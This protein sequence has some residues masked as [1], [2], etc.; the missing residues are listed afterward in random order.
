VGKL[1]PKAVIEE[2]KSAYKHAHVFDVVEV[3]KL[4]NYEFRTEKCIQGFYKKIYKLVRTAG[5]VE[6]GVMV[7]QQASG[8][9]EKKNFK[10]RVG[11]FRGQMQS[12]LEFQCKP[13]LIEDM[14]VANS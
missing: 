3:E 12:V 10:T 2:F 4:G 6:I 1:C 11:T 5:N 14:V 8:V 13:Q 7:C 9:L